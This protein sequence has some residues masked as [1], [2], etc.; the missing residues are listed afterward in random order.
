M[1]NPSM[2][3]IPLTRGYVALVDDEDFAYL[4]QF[5]WHAHLTRTKVYARRREGRG[6]GTAFYMHKE[7]LKADEVDHQDGD[8]LNNRRL[9]LRDAS[10]SQNMYNRA[11]KRGS[12]STFK[13]VHF[14]KRYQNWTAQCGGKHLGYFATEK[15]AARAYN[16][17]AA[18]LYGEFAKLNEVPS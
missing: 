11:A 10:H 7:I 16:E 12:S 13:G 4:S 14:Y 17:I 18:K 5:K 8:G 1:Y 9:N 2:K 6:P 15:E 3:E